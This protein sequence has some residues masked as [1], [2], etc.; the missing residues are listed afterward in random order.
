MDSYECGH[1][2][3]QT[4]TE[5]GTKNLQL[6]FNQEKSKYIQSSLEHTGIVH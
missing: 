6:C 1:H 5:M 3:A 4:W 2:I